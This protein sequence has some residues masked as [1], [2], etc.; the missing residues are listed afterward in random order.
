[1]FVACVVFCE[2]EKCFIYTMNQ[3]V[4]SIVKISRGGG[5]SIPCSFYRFCCTKSQ[6]SSPHPVSNL[7]FLKK[8][9]SPRETELDIKL[10]LKQESLQGKINRQKVFCHL[11]SLSNNPSTNKDWNHRYWEHHNKRFFQ[12]RDVFAK[13]GGNEDLTKYYTK[14]LEEN[15]NKHVEYSL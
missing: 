4:K 15:Y 12:G 1:M 11:L 2:R 14:F 5:G 7:R 9:P 8:N 6:V 13:G 3:K 10:R